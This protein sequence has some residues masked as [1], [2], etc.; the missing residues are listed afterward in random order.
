M[1]DEYLIRMANDIAAFFC[2]ENTAEEA[3]RSIAAHLKRF[4]DP[5]MRKQIVAL[6]HAGG[7]GLEPAAR[8]AVA[9]L[10]ADVAPGPTPAH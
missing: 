8:A 5:R 2:A 1:K 3:P 6:Y 4:W 10:A 9:L 7:S